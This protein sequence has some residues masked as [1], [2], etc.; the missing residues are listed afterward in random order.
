MKKNFLDSLIRKCRKDLYKHP[1]ILCFPHWTFIYYNY[2]L[3]SI[4]Q[5]RKHEPPKYFGYHHIEKD[6]YFVPKLHS[7]LDAIY[8]C[9]KYLN[10]F[11]AINIR[12]NKQKKTRMSKPCDCCLNILYANRC[13]KVYFTTENDDWDYIKLK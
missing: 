11:V 12:L 2:E 3:L 1:E 5:N 7:E 6:E 13:K 10:D 8:R 9:R 4:G